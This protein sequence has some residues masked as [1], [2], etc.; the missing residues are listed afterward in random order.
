MLNIARFACLSWAVMALVALLGSS[1]VEAQSPAQRTAQANQRGPQAQRPKASAPAANQQ[2]RPRPAS[3]YT[4]LPFNERS[5]VQTRGHIRKILIGS[6]PLQGN[7]DRFRD[8]FQRGLFAQMTRSEYLGQL[9]DL[10]Q[11]FLR[12]YVRATKVPAVYNELN[13]IT[14]KAMPVF[15]AGSYHPAVRYNATLIL[16]ELDQKPAVEFGPDKGPP[17][18]LA[19]ALPVL[20]SAYKSNKMPDLVKIGAMVGIHRHIQYRTDLPADQRGA[21]AKDM[22]DLLQE[23]EPPAGRTAEGHDWMRRR[24]IDMLTTIGEPGARGEVV[25]AL[26]G[27]IED[28]NESLA[29]RYHAAESI[30]RLKYSSAPQIDL[31]KLAVEFAELAIEAGK[32]EEAAVKE[33]PLYPYPSR[34][35]LAKGLSSV[36]TGI[37]GLEKVAAAED[38]KI[39]ADVKKPV[40][41]VLTRIED[42]SMVDQLLAT[43]LDGILTQLE[44]SLPRGAVPNPNQPQLPADG[45]PFSELTPPAGDKRS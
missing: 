37:E 29:M 5:L 15:I 36:C 4:E 16:G 1:S 10:R 17:V 12:Q 38:Q 44:A 3:N 7:E 23:K 35:R 14:L 30:G 26:A 21:I 13:Q 34:R 33:Q 22:Y 2:A 18:P 8:F 9:A 42:P 28:D 45:E 11:D 20:V 41:D 39:L 31:K 6:E 19:E 32:G 25:I 40:R 43:H 27:V 24:A